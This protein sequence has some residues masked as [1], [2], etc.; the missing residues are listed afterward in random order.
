MTLKL[1]R[2]GV[3]ALV[4]WSLLL[5]SSA[6]SNVSEAQSAQLE[7]LWKHAKASFHQGDCRDALSSLDAILKATPDDPWAKLYHALC[8]SRLQGTQAVPSLDPATLH[9]L[10][11]RLARE[12]ALQYR[13]AVKQRAI[14]R[15]IRKGQ[16]QWDQE[17]TRLDRE[18][19]RQ[20][21]QEPAASLRAAQRAQ[22]K[23]PQ[24]H[25]PA[26]KEA[27]VTTEGALPAL[28][29]PPITSQPTRSSSTPTRSSTVVMSRC[30]GARSS[31]PAR[32]LS[33]CRSGAG[34]RT[35]VASC[36]RSSNG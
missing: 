1:F 28:P 30:H 7:E 29:E 3:V 11:D 24:V 34:R 31:R 25:A 16:A 15:E 4:S 17:L 8:A 2:V 6:A 18:A 20:R 22:K 35:L 23:E 33:T 14:D 13:E 21:Q 10:T 26:R 5:S 19:K 12:E 27:A 32:R 36:R 9:S